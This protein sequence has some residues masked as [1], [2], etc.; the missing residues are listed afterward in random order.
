MF[1]LFMLFILVPPVKML[2]ILQLFLP[3]PLFR[4]RCCDGG[5]ALVRRIL[6]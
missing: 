6:H 5:K 3:E 1:L 4:R 2:H